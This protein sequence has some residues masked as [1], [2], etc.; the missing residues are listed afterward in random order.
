MRHDLGVTVGN[1]TPGTSR[2]LGNELCLRAEAHRQGNGPSW[3]QAPGADPQ[4]AAWSHCCAQGSP[5]KSLPS[6][7]S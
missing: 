3:R 4:R 7:S 5:R 1:L 2:P 6:A